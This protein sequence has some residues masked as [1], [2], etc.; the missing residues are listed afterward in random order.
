MANPWEA[1]GLEVYE[2][3]MSLD[4]VRQLQTLNRMMREQLEAY[5][6]RSAM[7]LGVAGGNGLE[8]VR[9]EKYDAV[10]GIDLNRDYLRA[11]AQR[12]LELDGV[13]RLLA[14]DLTRDAALLPP[15]ELVIANLLIEYIGYGSFRNAI[16]QILPRYISCVIQINGDAPEWVSDSPYL[17]AFDGLDAIHHQMEPQTLTEQ[18]EQIGF[19]PILQASEPLPN[20]KAF[21]R[22]DYR[23]S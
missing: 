11:A 23:R 16:E 6:V 10:Y 14:L 18:M 12:H 1:I 4:S 9:R 17:H 8:H 21:L 20:G 7:I 5:P 22:L 3:H 19:Q 15:A 2:R 13:L